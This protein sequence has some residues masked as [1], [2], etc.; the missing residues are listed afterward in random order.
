MDCC[1]CCLGL[2]IL[3]LSF[4]VCSVVGYWGLGWLIDCV[5]GLCFTRLGCGQMVVGM[6][7]ALGVCCG[8]IVVFCV[9]MY[10]LYLLQLWALVGVS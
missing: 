8:Q 2:L 4:V 1:V 5:G 10:W 6:C 3:V 7:C 9:N